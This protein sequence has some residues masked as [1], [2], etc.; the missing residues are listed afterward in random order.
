MVK[1]KAIER[2]NPQDAAAPKKFYAHAIASKKVDL[3]RLAYLVSNQCT[4]RESDCYAVLIALQHN[5]MDELN[6][7]NIVTLDKLGSFQIGVR[8]KGKALEEE[9]SAETV[10][11]AHLNFR[12]AKRMRKMLTTVEF[13]ITEG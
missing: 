10:K 5:I 13:T 6:Q 4:V 12:P 8:S 2:G 11:S 1:I 3:E 7:G 9:V